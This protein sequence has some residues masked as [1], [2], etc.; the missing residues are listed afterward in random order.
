MTKDYLMHLKASP[1]SVSFY[2]AKRLSYQ[3]RLE[4]IEASGIQE[5]GLE[6]KGP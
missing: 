3:R 6:I 5:Q 2:S 1:L 4:E